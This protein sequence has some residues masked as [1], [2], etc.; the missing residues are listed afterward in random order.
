MLV[1]HYL[2]MHSEL[3]ELAYQNNM[4]YTKGIAFTEDRIFYIITSPIAGQDRLAY[5]LY[6]QGRCIFVT[7]NVQS[8]IREMTR[9]LKL[10]QR[11]LNHD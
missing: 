4:H 6:M 9:Q 10:K 5:N 2:A 1:D 7:I 3:E 8:L 11:A